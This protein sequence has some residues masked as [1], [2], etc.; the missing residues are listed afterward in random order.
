LLRLWMS[1]GS[2]DVISSE[3]TARE[4]TNCFIQPTD[5]SP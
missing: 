1:R 4:P 5:S 3:Q 2:F